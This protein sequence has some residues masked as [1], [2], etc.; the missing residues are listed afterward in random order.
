MYERI[1]IAIDDSPGAERAIEHALDVADDEAAEVYALHVVDTRS[2]GEPALSTAEL[3]VDEAEDEGH[4]LLETFA[5][6]AASSGVPVTT[7][8]VHG[9]PH[10]EILTYAAEI[11]ADL[12]VLGYESKNRQR[13][14]GSTTRA[15]VDT[16]DR[17]V[18]TP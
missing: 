6:R 16:S 9:V 18:H 15:I 7:R 14:I 11:D 3:V 4:R 12:I 5:D 10:E 8:C 1:L 13:Y 2:F 17:A